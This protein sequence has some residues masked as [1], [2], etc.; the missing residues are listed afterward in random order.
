[1]SPTNVVIHHL[2]DFSAWNQHSNVD[3]GI[4]YIEFQHR[5]TEDVTRF[6]LHSENGL[7]FS[8]TSVI[9][10]YSPWWDTSNAP[11][12]N[13]LNGQAQ[14]ELVHQRW[15]HPGERSMQCLH[16]HID[17]IP[18][19]KGNNIH[20]CA[21]CMLAKATKRAINISRPSAKPDHH[22]AESSPTP[23]VYN[24]HC[25]RGQHFHIDFGFM[26]GSGYKTMDVDGKIVT[27]IDKYNSYLLIIDRYSRYTWVFLTKSKSPPLNI[28]R[29]FL[30]EHGPTDLKH[31][32][33]RTDRG[34]E[35]WGSQAFQ[36]VVKDF[37]YILEPTAR[38]A[39]FQNGMAERPNQTLANMVRCLLFSAGLGPEYWSFALVHA[40][41]LE[42][43]LPHRITGA[44]PYVLYT[45]NKPNGKHVR[46]FGCRV[47]TKLPG[48]RPAKLDSHTSAGIVLGYTATDKNIHYQDDITKEI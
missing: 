34:G 7:W 24:A 31:R 26:R 38:D 11:V 40:V 35:L 47:V 1:V 18:K 21:S 46:V 39:P 4:G 17:G 2:T 30:T 28:L 19:C 13:R 5:R 44:T 45:G 37:D 15:G 27:S 6:T 33:I 3:T 9:D 48:K 20:R 29:K 22:S 42:N 16:N 14:Y 25:Q 36:D 43:R 32:I 12:I 41:Y 23:T 8:Y 10:D